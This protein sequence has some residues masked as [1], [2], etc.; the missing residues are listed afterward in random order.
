VIIR[1][2]IIVVILAICMFNNVT[3]APV[4]KQTTNVHA[5]RIYMREITITSYPQQVY[6]DQYFNVR[7][8]LSAGGKGIGNA[9]ISHLEYTPDAP[10][11]EGLWRELWTITTDA[12]G[13]FTDNFHFSKPGRYEFAYSNSWGLGDIV[14]EDCTSDT[15]CIICQSGPT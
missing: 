15:L 1:L 12:S 14:P 7:G 6:V 8:F 5:A 10:K 9:R 11:G 2:S 3:A 13:S 4:S